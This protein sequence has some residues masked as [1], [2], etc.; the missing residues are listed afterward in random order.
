M[1]DERLQQSFWLS[2]FLRSDT[3]QRHGIDNTPNAIALANLRH[4][5]APGMQRVRNLLREPV[6]ITSGYRSPAVNRLVGGSA[7]SQHS[8]GLAADFVCPEF[9]PPRAICRKLLEHASE[10]RY[11]QL[12]FEGA[13]V[14]VSFVPT[15][16]R[17]QV[18]T[19]HFTAGGGVTYTPG[20]S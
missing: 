17:G 5:L 3:G 9:G 19:A 7:S 11:D 10:V 20:L 2:E 18:L 15:A 16:P 4:V 12:I 13:W 1:T 6:F 14:H 8:Q